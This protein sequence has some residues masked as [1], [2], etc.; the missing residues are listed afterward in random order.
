MHLS[1]PR[2]DAY[3]ESI[4]SSHTSWNAG[5]ATNNVGTAQ[6]E[7]CPEWLSLEADSQAELNCARRVYLRSHNA[8]GWSAYLL[9]WR[10]KSYMIERI[11]EL[12]CELQVHTLGD[13]SA[14]SDRE[15]PVVHVIHA[16]SV[17]VSGRVAEPHHAAGIYRLEARRVKPAIG[18]AG[19]TRAGRLQVATW[20][21]IGSHPEPLRP[22][23]SLTSAKLAES[24]PRKELVRTNGNT[25]PDGRDA[26][27]PPSTDN[28][29]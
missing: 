17:N 12:R 18:C 5:R 9:V 20:Y 11:K 21:K 1:K 8:E 10:A 15:V 6:H 7:R 26:V 25:A 23:V 27:D 2:S 3:E 24:R 13:V 16:N 28:R 22:E 29:I 14:L 19:F 4:G